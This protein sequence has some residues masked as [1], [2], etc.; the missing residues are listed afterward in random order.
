MLDLFGVLW[1]FDGGVRW[2]LVFLDL[3]CI[4]GLVCLMEIKV[5]NLV[6]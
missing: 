2:C 1:E 5:M 3:R 4:G 6:E